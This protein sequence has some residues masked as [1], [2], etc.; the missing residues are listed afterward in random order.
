VAKFPAKY[1]YLMYGNIVF[2]ASGPTFRT[3]LRFR[4]NS[5]SFV[6]H[7][8]T[9]EA[10]DQCIADNFNLTVSS[11]IADIRDALDDHSNERA[12]FFISEFVWSS[13]ELGCLVSKMAAACEVF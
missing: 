7:K 8:F 5:V 2:F 1:F 10:G 4:E 13:D 3:V 9:K 11:T 12:R 6:Q